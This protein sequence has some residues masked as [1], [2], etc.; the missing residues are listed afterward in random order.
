M[1]NEA[2]GYS[3]AALKL[4]LSWFVTS[5]MI[6]KCYSALFSDDCLFFFYEDSGDVTSCCNEMDVLSVNLGNINLDG[7]MKM[8]LILLFI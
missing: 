2:V 5:K 8:D 1:C 4:I 7:L 3:L 6:K